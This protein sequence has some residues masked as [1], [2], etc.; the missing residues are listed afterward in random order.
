MA[1]G[2]IGTIDSVDTASLKSASVSGDID[3]QL[4][5]IFDGVREFHLF[6][7]VHNRWNGIDAFK[8]LVTGDN[9]FPVFSPRSGKDLISTQY[10]IDYENYY[11]N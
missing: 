7:P 9:G 8:T 6:K 2:A 5:K 4:E 11:E 1:F 10:P 3:A